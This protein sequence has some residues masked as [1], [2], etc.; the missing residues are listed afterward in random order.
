M[1]TTPTTNNKDHATSELNCSPKST[2]TPS[3]RYVFPEG[4]GLGITTHCDNRH[5]LIEITLNSE[6]ACATEACQNLIIVLRTNKAYKAY[7][8][9]P[10]DHQVTRARLKK[11]PIPSEHNLESGLRVSLSKYGCILQ[12][13]LFNK[14][15]NGRWFAILI[16]L[17]SDKF[18]ELFHQMDWGSAEIGIV[19]VVS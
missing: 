1:A 7:Y 19:H 17:H 6:E 5:T 12:M 4:T 8:S 16:K 2:T 10:P 9:L 14:E 11:L 3:A 15:P 18:K 13:G